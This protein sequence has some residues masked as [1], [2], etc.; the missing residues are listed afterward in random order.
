MATMFTKE[1]LRQM[2]GKPVL[3]RAGQKIGGIEDIYLDDRTDEP[4]WVGLGTGFFGSKH[5]VVPLQ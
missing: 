2:R 5:V 4:E 3:D 1:S